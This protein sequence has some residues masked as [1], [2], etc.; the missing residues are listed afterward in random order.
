MTSRPQ[1]IKVKNL[2]NEGRNIRSIARELGVE[3]DYVKGVRTQIYSDTE[4]KSSLLNLRR[5]LITGLGATLVTIVTGDLNIREPS[6]LQNPNYNNAL[7]RFSNLTPAEQNRILSHLERY[8]LGTPVGRLAKY[9]SDSIQVYETAFPEKNESSKLRYSYDHFR[10]VIHSDGISNSNLAD[11]YLHG[12]GI[13]FVNAHEKLHYVQDINSRW[14]KLETFASDNLKERNLET[15]ILPFIFSS[16]DEVAEFVRNLTGKLNTNPDEAARIF[17]DLVEKFNSTLSQR[18]IIREIHARLT[19][20]P[21]TSPQDLYKSLSS[22]SPQYKSLLL[23]VSEF[24]F[25][26]AFNSTLELIALKNPIDAA[27]FVGEYGNTIREYSAAVDGLKREKKA[28]YALQ[29]GLALQDNLK[30]QALS[31]EQEAKRIIYNPQLI[32]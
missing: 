18:H 20:E 12:F 2:L 4:Q 21:W 7:Q 10:N 14:D 15:A 17:N 27:K 11:L 28:R 1:D 26:R 13:L 8:V 5:S 25:I 29:F 6:Q 32:H 3:R 16:S 9:V 30:K 23:E 31:I 19:F 24:E 22:N